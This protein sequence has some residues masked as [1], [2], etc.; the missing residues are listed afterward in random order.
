MSFIVD[1]DKGGFFPSWTTATRPASP[2]VGQMGYNTT[3][4]QFDVYN[5]GGWAS[6]PATAGTIPGNL[7]FASG[8]NGITFNNA[9]ALV[10]SKLSDYEEG[11]WTPNVYHQSSNN[12]SWS[13]K[14]GYYRKVG[15]IV[16]CW[17]VCDGG[18][19]GTSGSNLVLSGI[20]FNAASYSGAITF[21]IWG[22][23][24]TSPQNGGILNVGSGTASLSF[25]GSNAT[26]QLSFV[27]GMLTFFANF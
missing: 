12:S 3:T 11:T 23:N 16:T 7:S 5:S 17:W 4:G 20:P 10:N 14:K 9:S 15:S 24:G 2:A 27:S 18:N 6:I 19:S 8:T 1:G 26:A 22:N 13:T 25:G 21:G